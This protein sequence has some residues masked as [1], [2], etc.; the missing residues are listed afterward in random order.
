MCSGLSPTTSQQFAAP[1]GG[2]RPCGADLG[3]DLERLADDVADR[4]PRVQRGVRVLHDHLDVAAQP[5]C[6]SP[7]PGIWRCPRPCSSHRPAVGRSSAH[8]QPGQ[9]G[10]AAAGLADDAERLAATQVEGDPVDRLDR[11][12]LL[13]E[14]DALGEREVLDQ[15]ATSRS[16]RRVTSV[17]L[18]AGH[19]RTSLPEVTGA[20]RGRRTEVSSAAARRSTQTVLART[21]TAGGRGSPRGCRSRFGGRPLIGV[22]SLALLVQPGDRRPAGPWC[23]GGP[24]AR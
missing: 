9:R 21:G 7:A 16:S 11:A 12:D 23:T 18:R 17:A 24:G 1:A 6:S 2:G 4:H 5:A 8:Q 3:V 13:L 19:R 22:S 15:V 20:G 10:L 14:H